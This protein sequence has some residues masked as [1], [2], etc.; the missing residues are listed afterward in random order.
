[1]KENKF[2]NIL[3]VQRYLKN[4]ILHRCILDNNNNQGTSRYKSSEL[5][6]VKSYNF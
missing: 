6:T 1:M 2:N 3:S 5:C 4:D